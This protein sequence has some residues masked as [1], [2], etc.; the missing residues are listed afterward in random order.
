[1]ADCYVI[2]HRGANKI[3]PQNTLPA[4]R[5]SIDFH[6]DGFETDV[7]LTLDGV[8]VLCHNYSVDDTSNGKGLITAKTLEELKKL[9]FG[10]YFHRAYKGTKIPSLDEFLNL[11]KTASLKILNIEI[12]P[13]QN[14]DYSIV[15][16]TID[17]V[18]EKGLFDRLIISSFDPIVL[19]TCKDVEPQ[20]KTGFLYSP[21]S[22]GFIRFFGKE[23]DFA[24]CIG[25]N[26]LHPFQWLVDKKL[27]EKAHENGMMVNPW[28]V[29]NERDITRLVKIG[30][31][32]VIT[33]VPKD[34]RRII[35]QL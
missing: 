15:K 8:P 10:A 26:A 19:T 7:H 29:N 16:M 27:V 4:F 31:D 3:A 32:S 9:D 21:K 22:P 25:A 11:C 30:V 28:T 5:K 12:K 14:G 35:S 34:A 1:M 33:D 17:A 2:S 20:C 13:P 6:A 23:I 24:K 18:K